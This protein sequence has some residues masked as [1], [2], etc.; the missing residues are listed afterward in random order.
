MP[1]I[2]RQ[3]S[4]QSVPNRDGEAAEKEHGQQLPAGL[5]EVLTAGR[6]ALVAGGNPLRFFRQTLY[7]NQRPGSFRHVAELLE[8]L[9]KVEQ[10]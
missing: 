10:S 4:G 8:K 1:E 9:L 7:T 3:A 2:I 5:A 6:L